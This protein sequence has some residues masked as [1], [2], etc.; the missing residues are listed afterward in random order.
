MGQDHAFFCSGQGGL[1]ESAEL[2]D[3]LEKKEIANML[4]EL[5]PER[6][7]S[8]PVG[9]IKKLISHEQFAAFVERA[10]QDLYF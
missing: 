9:Q 10:Y 7:S 3:G 5:L 2:L 4:Y 1:S 8:I 6:I